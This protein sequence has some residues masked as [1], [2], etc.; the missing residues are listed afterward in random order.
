MAAAH[1]NCVALQ[2]GF[3]KREIWQAEEEEE[4]E[5]EGGSDVESEGEG[6]EREGSEGGSDGGSDTA[7]KDKVG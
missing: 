7:D 3:F 6:P 1:G 4:E 5:E 2:Q